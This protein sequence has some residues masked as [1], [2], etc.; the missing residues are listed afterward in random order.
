MVDGTE[1]TFASHPS[2]LLGYLP[3][4]TES[5][6]TFRENRSYPL[7]RLWPSGPDWSSASK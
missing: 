2:E 6:R 3:P 4:M 1:I 7:S 5:S